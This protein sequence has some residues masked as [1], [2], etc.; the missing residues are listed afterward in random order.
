MYLCFTIFKVQTPSLKFSQII[1]ASLQNLFLY[2]LDVIL[3]SYITH[4]WT[5]IDLKFW[6]N[7][8]NYIYYHLSKFQFIWLHEMKDLVT[9]LKPL[10]LRPKHK[11]TYNSFSTTPN[12]LKIWEKNEIHVFHICSKF[13]PLLM[14]ITNSYHFF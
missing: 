3:Q 9:F 2:L 7:M 4:I 8:K 12:T 13:W 11:M 1:F 6:C 10:Q 5:Q 14:M